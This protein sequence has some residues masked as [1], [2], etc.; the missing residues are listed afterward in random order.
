M[1][2]PKP[3]GIHMLCN[4]KTTPHGLP[5]KIRPLLNIIVSKYKIQSEGQEIKH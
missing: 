1:Y 4:Q 5:S 3:T 2:Q